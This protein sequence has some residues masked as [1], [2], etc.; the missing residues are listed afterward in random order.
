MKTTLTILAAAMALAASTSLARAQTSDQGSKT[1]RKVYNRLIQE[2]R[3]AHVELARA[4]KSGVDEAR[5]NNGT[6]ST[7]TRAKI[8]SLRD[9][10][11]RKNVRLMLVADRHGWEVPEFRLEDFEA[12]AEEPVNTNLTDQF[13]PPDPRITN[14][15]AEEA[16]ALAS[17]VKLPIIPA[18]GKVKIPRD[19]D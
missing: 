9:E 19:D 16:K 17:R 18:A 14:V 7:R 11:D 3:Q 13:F 12:E 15:L 8:V 2:I 10:I 5:A 1:D 6:A 4:Y